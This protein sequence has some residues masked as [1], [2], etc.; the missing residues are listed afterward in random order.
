MESSRV[1]LARQAV[2]AHKSRLST[3][4]NRDQTRRQIAAA[5]EV[6]ARTIREDS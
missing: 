2:M 4:A 5:E 3:S 1:K 6:L